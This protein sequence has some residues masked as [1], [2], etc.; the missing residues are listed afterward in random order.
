MSPEGEVARDVV[1]IGGEVDVE[2][3]V[4]GDV[5]A[6]GGPVSIDGKVTG[7]VVAVGGNVN[8]GDDAEVLGEVTS[9]G[10][11]VN[12]DDGAEVAG[13][14]NEVAFGPSFTWN[15]GDHDTQWWDWKEHRHFSPFGSGWFGFGLSL[16]GMV[17]LLMLALLVR[18]VAG[19]TVERVRAKAVEAPWMCALVGL[20][21][22]LFFVPVLIVVAVILAISIIGIPLLLLIPF[23]VLAFLVAL[24]VGYA[25]VA[26]TVG[27]SAGRRFGRPASSPFLAIIFGVF[28]IQFIHVIAEFFDSFSGFMF[29]FAVM[30]GVAGFL[31][32][33]AAWT[34]G[35]GAVFLTAVRRSGQAAMVVPPP[36][37]AGYPPSDAYLPPEPESPTY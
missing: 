35:I 7:D 11:R 21:I 23:V 14:I 36:P 5:V 28:L 17:V 4:E 2:G 9:V 26:Q 33:Y 8:L 15:L 12:R 3:D 6:V 32:R 37:P 30:F 1:A 29:F 22:E 20:A 27:E 24:V 16:I 34:V 31:V 25:A 19:G 18:L 10:G 13:H